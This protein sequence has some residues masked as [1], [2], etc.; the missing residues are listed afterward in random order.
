MMRRTLL[1]CLSAWAIQSSARADTLRVG[2]GEA[3]AS[4]QDA[5]DAAA[6]GDEIRVSPGTYAP[7]ETTASSL[8]IVGDGEAVVRGGGLLAD[9][10]HDDVLLQNL[11]FDGEEAA[12]RGVRV[13]GDGF[14]LLNSEVRHVA[15]NC[16]DLRRVDNALI[17]G[18]RLHHCLRSQ[19]NG[20]ASERCRDDAHGIVG[21]A[22]QSL[23]VRDSEIYLFSGDAIQIDSGWREAD[24]RWTDVLVEGCTFWSAPLEEATRAYAAGINPAENAID[25]KTRP[26]FA[27]AT[28]TVRDTV[29]HGFRGGL[30]P[31][32]SAF[33][34]KQDVVFEIDRVTVYDS[35]IAFRVRGAG[36]DWARGAS[37]TLT[38]A[39]I[40][41]VERAIRYED[42]LRPLTISHCTFGAGVDRAFQD[43][44]SGAVSISAVNNL[45]LGDA[46]PSELPAGR[47]NLAVSAA[48]FVNA[49]ANDYRLATSASAI[50][51]GEGNDV[52]TDRDGVPR[53]QGE[54]FD[55]GAFEACG[56]CE[57]APMDGGPPIDGGSAMDAGAADAS[58]PSS[59]VDSGAGDSGTALDVG[60]DAG[61]SDVEGGG[62]C[63]VRTTGGAWLAWLLLFAGLRRRRTVT[64]AGRYYSYVKKNRPTWRDQSA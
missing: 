26:G 41:D 60:T 40:Y 21:G 14:T 6:E 36:G 7:F 16:V 17:D 29:A 2:A 28:M 37:L 51:A 12:P 27:D 56:D 64:H 39:V 18:S 44:S 53:P 45:V 3:F 59:D 57:P 11:V 20:C 32:M 35:E 10:R 55:V 1:V 61:G 9:I 15:G 49:S 47:F 31:N 22:V 48:E 52:A 13:Q 63:A 46:L 4:I 43:S 62:G 38:N 25:T 33:N 34:L 50:D 30:I 5:L 54:G 8:T 23:T 42:E 19:S 58:A 24:R